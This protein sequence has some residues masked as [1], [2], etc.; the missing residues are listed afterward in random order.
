M[1]GI[2]KT[3]LYFFLI[4]PFIEPQI[5]KTPGFAVFDKVYLVAKL[6][7][8]FLIILLYINK[9]Y[10]NVS[11]YVI[12]MSLTQGCIFIGTL[13]NGG[14]IIR[15]TGP[16]IASIVVIIYGEMLPNYNWKKIIKF[17]EKYLTLF[18]II[19]L[20]TI[21]L[22]ELG[23]TILVKNETTFLGIDNRWIYFLLP[24]TIIA[25]INDYI[26]NNKLTYSIIVYVVSFLSLL[27]VWSAGAMIAYII[28]PIAYFIL[29]RVYAHK[30]IIS[31]FISRIVFWSYLLINFLLVNNII[32]LSLKPI[33]NNVLHKDITL[34]GRIYLWESVL[35]VLKSNPLFGI[36]F[37]THDYDKLFFYESSG[38]IPA[39]RVNHPH[40]HLA[41][42]AYHGGWLALVAFL[43]FV[44]AF[45]TYIDKINDKGIAIICLSSA[46]AIF[47][48]ALV[49]TLDF[50]LFYLLIPIII[51]LNKDNQLRFY[52]M[53]KKSNK[54]I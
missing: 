3:Q 39:T 43:I 40:N 18:F 35:D 30:N 14:S 13:I 36:G 25:M 5:F 31:R 50:S 29:I 11:K 46:I 27:Y 15:F 54:E 19:N 1:K 44:Y 51:V 41:Y 9:K 32:L 23:V 8:A 33:I 6:L 2:T 24:W 34:A 48:A 52:R 21:P 7:A 45:M 10:F 37:Q 49:D 17:I 22:R 20:L 12:L 26:K 4:L 53:I 42:V 38:F 28:L 16:A 47:S